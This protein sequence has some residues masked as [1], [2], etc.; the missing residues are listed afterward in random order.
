VPGKHITDQQAK[1]YM[2]LRRTHT[3]ETAAAK[4]GFSTSTGARLD[5]DAQ[6]PSQKRAPRGRRR[7]DPLAEYW[8]SEIVPMLRASPG[9]RPIT[10]LLEMQRRHASFPDNLRRTLE[11]RVR[12]WQALHGPEREVIFRQEHPPGQQALSDFTD[13]MELGVSIAGT[14][15][16]HRLYHFRLAFSGW[17]QAHV[18]LG[19]ESFVALAEGLQNALWSLGGAPEEHRSDSLSG[20]TPVSWRVASLGSE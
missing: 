8:D 4:A 7:P 2:N 10:L 5:A 3:R 19:G 18:V 1:L 13:A 16:D 6:M 17:E 15:L 14:P 20:L 11:R 12:H 9:L